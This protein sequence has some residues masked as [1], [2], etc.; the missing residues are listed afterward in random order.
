[1]LGPDRSP[2]RKPEDSGKNPTAAAALRADPGIPPVGLT[3]PVRP[4][5]S[6][7]NGREFAIAGVPGDGSE[8]KERRG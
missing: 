5:Q 2:F 7:H 3:T 8:R 1:M 4:P 6:I